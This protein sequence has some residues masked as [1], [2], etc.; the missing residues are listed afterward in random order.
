MTDESFDAQFRALLNRGRVPPHWPLLCLVAVL[1]D[2]N[3]NEVRLPMNAVEGGDWEVVVPFDGRLF[4]IDMVHEDP[5]SSTKAM[6]RG[7]DRHQDVA[8][9]E[10]IHIEA[11][12]A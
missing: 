10:T 3:A 7:A 1:Y 2:G 4:R 12:P 11:M 9:G 6:V 8:A 5:D